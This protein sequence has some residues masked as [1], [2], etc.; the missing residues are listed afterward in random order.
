MVWVVEM[1]VSVVI[2]LGLLDWFLDDEFVICRGREEMNFVGIERR[3]DLE[4]RDF[5]ELKEDGKG[6]G[7]LRFVVMNREY[8]L[9][10]RLLELQK[11]MIELL[12]E[13]GVRVLMIE[14]LRV[15]DDSDDNPGVRGGAVKL[16]G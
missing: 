13:I 14:K 10:L 8:V 1:G 16:K 2:A 7:F 5:E 6:N 12:L 9:M 3:L 11:K 15:V 4:K